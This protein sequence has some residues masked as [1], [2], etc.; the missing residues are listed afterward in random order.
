MLQRALQ[1]K[2]NPVIKNITT[3]RIIFLWI[4]FYIFGRLISQNNSALFNFIAFSSKLW[5]HIFPNWA[6]FFYPPTTFG[7]INVDNVAIVKFT[8]LEFA[9]WIYFTI[10][11]IM[12]TASDNVLMIIQKTL[13]LIKINLEVK[14]MVIRS[15]ILKN[16]VGQ[17]IFW[18][19]N[20][21]DLLFFV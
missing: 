6:I 12:W 11:C 16:G 20:L 2:V 19:G 5:N 7:I 8:I 1:N 13:V 18:L 9:F 4:K 3:F 15:T 17:I 14:C 21:C 10:L